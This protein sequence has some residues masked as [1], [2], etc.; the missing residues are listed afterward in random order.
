[1]DKDKG[2]L[3]GL[4]NQVEPFTLFLDNMF[5]SVAENQFNEISTINDMDAWLVKV[6]S[7][8]EKINFS[9]E[10][11]LQFTDSISSY[12]PFHRCDNKDMAYYFIENA[13]FRV[14]CLWDVHAQICNLVFKIEKPINNIY[15]KKFFDPIKNKFDNDVF[16]ELQKR[17]HDYLNQEDLVKDDYELWEGNHHF[18]SE[19]RNKFTH[20]NDPHIFSIINSNGGDFVI[21]NPP[22]Y[23]LKRLIED[24]Y[25]CY[26]FLKEMYENVSI[27]TRKLPYILPIHINK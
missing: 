25:I 14:A 13:I 1:M 23:E 4:L 8:L 26:S 20:R 10:S 24:Y 27:N 11:A 16:I 22:L 19:I 2:Y 9:L 5:I 3:I 18:I 15:Y 6:N 7:L 21:P 12:N 17:V